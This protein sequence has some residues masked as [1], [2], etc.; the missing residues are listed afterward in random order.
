MNQ[1]NGEAA[2]GEDKFDLN[3]LDDEESDDG[4]VSDKAIIE[5]I[6][7]ISKRSQVAKKTLQPSIEVESNST[8]FNS[9]PFLQKRNEDI[10]DKHSPVT[11][12]L[13]NLTPA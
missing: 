6:K 4:S 11:K 9:K 1:E 7:N 2:L 8:G 13:H 5:N 12:F 3:N 10:L